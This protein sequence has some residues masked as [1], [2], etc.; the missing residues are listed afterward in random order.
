MEIQANFKKGDQAYSRLYD[1]MVE[2]IK[3]RENK[4]LIIYHGIADWGEG[5][6]EMLFT[7][8][9]LSAHQM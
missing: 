6:K 8:Y 1:C 4:G 3:V 5:P 2:I 9:E 7:D